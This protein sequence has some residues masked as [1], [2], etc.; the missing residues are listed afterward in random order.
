MGDLMHAVT[1]VEPRNYCADFDGNTPPWRTAQ[2]LQ[3]MG[4]A[5]IRVPPND[6]RDPRDEIDV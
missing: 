1:V 3:E 5:E 4:W 2:A 6:L